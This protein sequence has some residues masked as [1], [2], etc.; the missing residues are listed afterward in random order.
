MVFAIVLLLVAVIGG[1]GVWFFLQQ[2][3]DT[4]TTNPIVPPTQ[5][6]SPYPTT[7]VL[8][9]SPAALTTSTETRTPPPLE[10]TATMVR[11]TVNPTPASPV[12]GGV[13][14]MAPLIPPRPASKG[15]MVFSIEDANNQDHSSI[16]VIN[17][18][19][20]E[21]KT[22]LD[23]AGRK[24]TS[25]AWSP[26]GQQIVFSSNRDGPLNLYVMNADG[27]G[28]R[29]LTEGNFSDDHPA[30]SPDGQR[31]AFS[32]DRSGARNIYT[33]NADGSNVQQ[34][35]DT[36]NADRYPAWSPD[37]KYIAFE[38]VLSGRG[39]IFVMNADGTGISNISQQANARDTAPTWSPDSSSIVFSSD[40]ENNDFD[41][42]VV[43]VDG[44]GLF[45]LT[46]TTGLDTEPSWSADGSGIVFVSRRKEGVGLYVM[47][48]DGTN[49]T[50]F[51]FGEVSSPDWRP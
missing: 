3:Q 1:G 45:R 36:R 50:S 19:G 16:A 25:P 15:Q 40:R 4:G 5:Q 44:S 39:E 32:S 18:D 31:I 51:Y 24:H 38:E 29:R 41:I 46:T 11:P 10:P 49:Q 21:L 43:K 23:S 47:A 12:G 26:D 35:T 2:Q 6:L 22:L 13:P 9:L 27:S 37:G 30:W 48:A 17:T 8:A 28:V 14:T 20:G 33:I 42:Y 7:M 34:L